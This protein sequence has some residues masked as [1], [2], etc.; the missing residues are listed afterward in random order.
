MISSVFGVLFYGFGSS[1][2]LELDYK[3]FK[4][5]NRGKFWTTNINGVE[6]LFTFFPS[7][8]ENIKTEQNAINRLK[9]IAEIDATSNFNDT[10]AEQIALAQ[11]QIGITLNNFNI[12]VRNGF[13]ASNKYNANLITCTN[14][15]K[16]VPVIFFKSSNETKITL[17]ND[18]IIAEASKKEDVLKLKDRI[19]YGIFNIIQ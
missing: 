1:G 9:N 18:C 10:F 6:A 3:N 13:A 8:V 7:D 5:I 2:K 4:F 19:A 11:Y 15:T 16:F 17:E 14:S 12:F